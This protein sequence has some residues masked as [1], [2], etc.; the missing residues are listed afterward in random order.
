MLDSKT[1]FVTVCRASRRAIPMPVKIMDTSDAHA[2][3][4]GIR[5]SPVTATREYVEMSAKLSDGLRRQESIVV[6]LPIDAANK[7][8]RASFKRAAIKMIRRLKLPY[9][10]RGLR[11]GDLDIILISNEEPVVTTPIRKAR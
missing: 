8:K 3:Y 10:V 7:H 4:A 6:E 9:S 11:Q 1:R 5:T 2:K